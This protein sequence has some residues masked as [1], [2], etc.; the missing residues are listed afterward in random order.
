MKVSKVSVSR[1]A[2]PP[3]LGQVVLRHSGSA[4]IGDWTPMNCTS[5]GNEVEKPLT[6]LEIK[7]ELF[8]PNKELM[9]K[10]HIVIAEE[11]VEPGDEVP[12]Y[13]ACRGHARTVHIMVEFRSKKRMY[14]RVENPGPYPLE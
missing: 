10:Q 6:D 14:L 13:V 8:A 9:S 4:L 12:F 11:T 2:A 5:S 3:H 1:S 7:L